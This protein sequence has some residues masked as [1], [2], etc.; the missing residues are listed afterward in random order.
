MRRC[1][2]CGK[3]YKHLEVKLVGDIMQLGPLSTCDCA[4]RAYDKVMKERTISRLLEGSNIASARWGDTLEDFDWKPEY[5]RVK[6]IYINYLENLEGNIKDGRGL[7]LFGSM[8]T[9]KTRLLCYVIIRIIK[10]FQIPCQYYHTTEL[11]EHLKDVYSL[12]RMRVMERCKEVDVL[13]LDDLG[14]SIGDYNIRYGIKG[15]INYRYEKHRV[16]FA[17]S[18]RPLSQ[19]EDE[20]YLGGHMVSR[21]VEM[22]S[23]VEIKDMADWRMKR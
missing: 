5:D 6:K 3:P 11:Y 18:M 10:Y 17:N 21:L 1:K 12:D 8:G 9:G 14:E 4:S 7:F 23:T 2:E 15:I 13:L 16:T 22:N 20:R 19:L